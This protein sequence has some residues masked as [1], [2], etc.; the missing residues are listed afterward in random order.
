MKLIESITEIS[1]K[2]KYIMELKDYVMLHSGLQRKKHAGYGVVILVDGKWRERI[3]EYTFDSEGLNRGTLTTFGAYAP[4]E[5]RQKE[6]ESDK[7]YNEVQFFRK[8]RV[9]KY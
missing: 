3:S 7:L 8:R 2:L 5:N 9:H 6:D 4:E 1:K